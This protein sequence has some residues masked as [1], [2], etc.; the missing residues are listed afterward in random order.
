M[1]T[2]KSSEDDLVYG[3]QIGA[4]D[5]LVKPFSPRELMARVMSLL[6]RTKNSESTDRGKTMSFN[7][8]FLSIDPE[9][10]EVKL[11]GTAVSLTP[12]EFKLLE[13]LAKYPKRVFGRSELVNLIQG[14]DFEGM[15]RTI[16]VHIKNIRQKIGDDPKTPTFIA[17][18][19]G[20][21]YKFQVDSDE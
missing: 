14:D 1:L 5:Y 20:I 6:R 17:T 3:L 8:S 12:I 18:V 13:I 11:G 4:D 21:G 7:K 2:A 10:Y 9:R 15:D 16:D 19:Y